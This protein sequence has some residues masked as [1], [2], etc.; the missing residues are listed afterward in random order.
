MKLGRRIGAA[1][2]SISLVFTGIMVPEMNVQAEE[3][4]LVIFSDLVVENSSGEITDDNRATDVV[5]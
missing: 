5:Q 4:S 2:L 3:E 1:V